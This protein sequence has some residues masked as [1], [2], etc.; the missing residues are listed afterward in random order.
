MTILPAVLDVVAPVF[1]VGAF[2]YTAGWLRWLN[3][4]ERCG[5]SDII[6]LVGRSAVPGALFALGGALSY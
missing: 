6:N 3:S 1:G 5:A 4:A 2:G